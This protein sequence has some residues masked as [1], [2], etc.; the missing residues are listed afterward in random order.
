MGVEFRSISGALTPL[1]TT[2]VGPD[3]FGAAAVVG[4]S[5]S[6]ARAD[7]DHGLPA[8]PAVPAAATTVTGPDAF[9]AAAVVGTSTAYARADHDHGLPAA[10]S[11]TLSTVSGVLGAD[12][13]VAAATNTL[14]MTSGT[15]A[16]G[17][18]LVTWNLTVK[19]GAAT[20]ALA[21]AWVVI[22]TGTATLNGPSQADSEMPAVSTG[23]VALSFTTLVVV[24][25]AATLSLYVATANASTVSVLGYGTTP[26]TTAT[27]YT[28]IK[29]A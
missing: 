6:A 12:V 10:P 3:A 17:T 18:W 19:N 13:A 24:T 28:A 26:A 29:V 15:L 23:Y 16:I 20:A 2:V 7:H 1:A 21:S 22:A 5:T 25:A 27:G 9:G 11:P 4:T 14:V 8:A